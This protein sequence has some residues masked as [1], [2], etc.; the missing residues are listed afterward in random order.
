MMRADVEHVAPGRLGHSHC[1]VGATPLTRA[2]RFFCRGLFHS[3]A[4]KAAT[5]PATGRAA[6]CIAYCAPPEWRDAMNHA[7]QQRQGNDR[8]QLAKA[9]LAG[10]AR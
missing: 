2:A 8:R 3:A 7:A 1:R 6:V 9:R 4:G 5:T 10:E